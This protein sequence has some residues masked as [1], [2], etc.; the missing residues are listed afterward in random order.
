V[1]K[2]K[3]VSREEWTAA[4]KKLLPDEAELS[5]ARQAVNAARLELPV[6]E[7]EKDYVFDGP[8]GKVGLADM[9]EGRRQLIVYHFMFDPNWDQGCKHC[10]L[11]ADNIGHLS[12]L[13]ARNTMLALVSRAPWSKIEP[14]KARMGWAVPWYSSFGSDF[15]YD[16]HVTLDEKIAPVEYNF[17]DKAALESSGSFGFT[18]GEASGLSVFLSEDGK[19]YHSYSSYDGEDVLY[20]TFNFL[21]LTPLGRQEG[22]RSW[23]RY[24][25]EYG[26]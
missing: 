7:V 18:N 2:I 11:L 5:R 15:N 23:L 13:H 16:Y 3:V 8:G 17:M 4:R 22:D 19:I 26:D 6:V 14:F 10:S 9:F 25:D 1:E 21:D 24:H 12:H 20:G